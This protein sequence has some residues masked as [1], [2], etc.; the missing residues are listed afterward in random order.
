MAISK[1]TDITIIGIHQTSNKTETT[2]TNN[3]IDIVTEQSADSEIFKPVFTAEDW[4]RCLAKVEHLDK[5]R[6]KGNKIRKLIKTREIS[7][8]TA[9][10]IPLSNKIL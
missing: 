8:K 10:Q 9:T 3:D 5:I 1:A 4:G 2:Q 6:K 7:L